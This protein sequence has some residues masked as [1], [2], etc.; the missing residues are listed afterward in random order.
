MH[1]RYKRSFILQDNFTEM[2]LKAQQ[3]AFNFS[4]AMVLNTNQCLDK[5][6]HFDML[7]GAGLKGAIESKSG[8]GFTSLAQ[9]KTVN[10]NSFLMGF[11]GYDLKNELEQLNS[12]LPDYCD[13]PDLYFFEPEFILLFRNN[14]LTV[15]SDEPI[16]DS[17]ME[18]QLADLIFEN[19]YSQLPKPNIQYRTSKEKYIHDVLQLQ[20][21]IRKGS[22]YEINY[23][24]E[25]YVENIMLNPVSTFFRYNLLTQSPLASMLKVGSKY[26]FSASPERFLQ[27][28]GDTVIAQ[29]MKGT[30]RRS[31]NSLEDS[32][33]KEL[34]QHSSKEQ[35]E[36]VMIVDLM[37][38]D[39][40]RSEA[41]AKINV[42][43]LFGVY[44]FAK[45]HQMISTVE[46]QYSSSVNWLD[47][48]KNAFP[49]GSMTGAPKISA[50]K[51]IEEYE[52][53]KRG[54]FS[55]ALGYITSNNDFDFSV[56]IRTIIYNQSTGY[57]SMQTGGAITLDSNPEA[58]YE[59]S[60]LKAQGLRDLFS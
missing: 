9:Y 12:T 37:R 32:K 34:L 45:V 57:L 18:V 23:C 8:N 20:E 42:A 48:L 24:Q 11:L 51:L 26:I 4:V 58:E 21:Y 17:F 5:Y 43:E 47:I 30:S 36:N 52:S 7:I 50:M 44:S 33:L 41:E 55:G 35:A 59:E 13:L 10:S 15:F 40:A 25:F 16:L 39:F 1:Y 14:E 29:P 28:K 49:I 19:E 31:S 27:K 3:W 54:L 56:V 60:L 2:Q 46:A 38:N 22:I 53:V 6:G